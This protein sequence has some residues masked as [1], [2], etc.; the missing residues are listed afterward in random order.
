[1]CPPFHVPKETH[2]PFL[3]CTSVPPARCGHAR[4][5][6]PGRAV[7]DGSR[8]MKRPPSPKTSVFGDE[9]RAS[10]YHPNSSAPRG[11][12][13]ARYSR[14]SASYPAALTG[15]TRRSLRD[16]PSVRGSGTIFRAD[17]LCP[18]P[19]SG[20]SVRSM[21]YVL[22]PS[23]PFHGTKGSA[24]FMIVILFCPKVKK[25]RKNRQERGKSG[26]Q[27]AASDCRSPAAGYRLSPAVPRF[28]RT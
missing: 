19:P 3:R 8:K 6:A 5:R 22:F 15:G 4:L 27:P 25:K 24:F 7:V 2:H 11:A 18:F 1:M 17:R 14:K 28:H 21:P 13:L 12:N 20:L 10:R 16:N 9:S 23:S 26:F